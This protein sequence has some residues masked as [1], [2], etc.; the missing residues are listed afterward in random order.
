M[1]I[2][3]FGMILVWECRDY[4]NNTTLSCSVPLND[5]FTKDEALRF[6]KQ[7]IH[8]GGTWSTRECWIC[9]HGERVN[10]YHSYHNDGLLAEAEKM[11]KDLH[12]ISNIRLQYDRRKNESET[13]WHF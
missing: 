7:I 1:R 3:D 10:K 9:I 6:L 13:E 5:K 12:E 2:E 8:L 4:V 11:Y